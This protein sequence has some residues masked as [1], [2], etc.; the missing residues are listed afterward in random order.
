MH[1]TDAWTCMHAR[2]DKYLGSRI[3]QMAH[4]TTNVKLFEAVARQT[5]FVTISHF[6]ML[7]EV[8]LNC[9]LMMYLK[10]IL[11]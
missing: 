3:P 11:L 6:K 5:L 8:H 2:S 1:G 10:D 9:I 4:A 7:T